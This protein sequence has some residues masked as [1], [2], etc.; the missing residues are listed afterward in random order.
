MFYLYWLILSPHAHLR[1]T[2]PLA[3]APRVVGVDGAVF[4]VGSGGGEGVGIGVVGAGID[5]E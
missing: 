1:D 2:A 4:P 3:G 5:G